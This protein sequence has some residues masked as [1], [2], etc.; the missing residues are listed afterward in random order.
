MVNLCE[1]E[2]LAFGRFGFRLR[3]KSQD[4]LGTDLGQVL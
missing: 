1:Q 4:D 2:R 3:T